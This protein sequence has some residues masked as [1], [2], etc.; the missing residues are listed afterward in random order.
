MLLI[1]ERS[2]QLVDNAN[3]KPID[4]PQ[5]RWLQRHRRA[6]VARD[7]QLRQGASFGWCNTRS[8]ARIMIYIH[9]S[10]NRIRWDRSRISVINRA[11]GRR[12]REPICRHP[13][14]MKGGETGYLRPVTVVKNK[15]SIRGMWLAAFRTSTVASRGCAIEAL[16]S[17]A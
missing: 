16:V 14:S 5:S 11:K 2:F 13:R 4:R 17:H 10:H 3:F 12:K 6:D 7:H 8:R 9:A 1:H 15:L